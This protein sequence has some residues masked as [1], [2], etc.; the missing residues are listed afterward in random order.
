MNP[1]LKSMLSLCKRSG[2]LLSGDVQVTNAMTKNKAKLV[3]IVGDSS[4]N[5]EDT[6]SSKSKHYNI[7]FIKFGDRDELNMSVGTVN[8]AVFCV[9]D[10]NFAK[11]IKELIEEENDA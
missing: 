9:T 3:I 7:D 1:K 11:R 5:T 6:F 4:K 8:K 10:E 2:N